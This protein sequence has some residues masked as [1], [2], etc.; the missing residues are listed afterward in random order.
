MDS[1]TNFNL[2]TSNDPKFLEYVGLQSDYL[3]E[4]FTNNILSVTPTCDPTSHSCVID[5]NQV[6]VGD[7]LYCNL[8]EEEYREL[9][10]SYITPSWTEWILI[11]SHIVVFLL[12][13]VSRRNIWIFW[14]VMWGRKIKIKLWNV[15]SE[16]FIDGWCD[17]LMVTE[18]E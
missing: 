1:L 5:H 3:I 14:Y 4:N 17:W 10:I 2:S 12:G 13:L 16:Q 7:M 15:N 8:T 18:L 11:F 6:C 9:L